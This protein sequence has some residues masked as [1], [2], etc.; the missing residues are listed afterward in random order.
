M[1][2]DPYAAAFYFRK[3]NRQMI[4][5]M[6]TDCLSEI[7]QLQRQPDRAK[8]SESCKMM[9]KQQRRQQKDSSHTYGVNDA[10]H[11]VSGNGSKQGEGSSSGRPR[12]RRRFGWMNLSTSCASRR[13]PPTPT[14]SN[15]LDPLFSR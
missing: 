10:G 13:R 14:S 12:R 8:G 5:G 3:T 1:I 15:H 11:L 9:N 2:H 6:T 4:N 7:L